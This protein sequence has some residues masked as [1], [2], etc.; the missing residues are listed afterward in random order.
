MDGDQ[1]D[2]SRLK[3]ESDEALTRN[4]YMLLHGRCAVCHWPAE[5]KGRWLELHHIMGG[6]GRKD[7]PLGE[8][9]LCTCNRC[10]NHLH[11][12]TVD[13]GGLAPGHIITAK[14]EEDGPIDEQKLAALRGRKSLPYE[15]LPIPKKYL[16]DRTRRGGDPWP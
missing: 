2:M 4:D 1:Q 10:H 14:E 15:R 16:E 13:R 7:L 12:L 3:G 6:A 5:R 8:N 11:Q 9:W